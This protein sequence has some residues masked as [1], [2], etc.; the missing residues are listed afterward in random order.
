MEIRTKQS[1]SFFFFALACFNTISTNNGFYI[2]IIMILGNLQGVHYYTLS[3]AIVSI[4]ENDSVEF[5]LKFNAN[6]NFLS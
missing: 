6:L 4:Y 3:R 5:L 1:L 2:I